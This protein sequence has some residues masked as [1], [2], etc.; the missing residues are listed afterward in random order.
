M[1]AR[2]HH[3]HSDRIDQHTIFAGDVSPALIPPGAAHW[4]RLFVGK[5]DYE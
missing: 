4:A 5:G 2:G 1:N 3:R